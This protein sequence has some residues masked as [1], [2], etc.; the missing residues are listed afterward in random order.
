MHIHNL[1]GKKD[2]QTK[3]EANPMKND[4][5]SFKA[6]GGRGGGRGKEGGGG[7]NI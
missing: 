3:L 7:G 6:R 2:L 5:V 1:Y 4:K